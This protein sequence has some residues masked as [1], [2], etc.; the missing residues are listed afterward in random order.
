MPEVD[1][2]AVR[3]RLLTEERRITEEIEALD[4]RAREEQAPG[5]A[6]FGS[7]EQL[8]DDA[9]LA[10]EREKDQALRRNLKAVLLDIRGALTNLDRGTYGRCDS[11]GEPISPQRLAALPHTTLCIKCKTKAEKARY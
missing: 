5:E 9:A 7:G 1:L 10:V 6:A 3:E 4:E 8:A 11:C 2:G